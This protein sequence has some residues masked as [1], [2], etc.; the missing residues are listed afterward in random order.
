MSKILVTGA[1]G[2][3]GSNLKYNLNQSGREW[4]GINSKDYDLTNYTQAEAAIRKIKPTVI[5]HLAALSGGIGANRERPYEFFYINSLLVANVFRAAAEN[6]VTRMIYTMGGC[7]YPNMSKSPISEDDM[8]NGFPHGD[9]SAYSSAK[10]LGI[11]A[12]QAYKML[13]LN[14]TVLVP[15]NLYGPHDNY[16]IRNSHVIPALIHKFATAIEGETPFV[17]LWGDGTP[18]RDFVYVKDVT[19]VINEMVDEAEIEGPLNISSGTRISIKELAELTQ[20]LMG[21]NGVIKWD[22]SKPNGQQEKIFDVS[23]LNNL[24]YRCDTKIEKGLKDTIE[25]FYDARNRGELRI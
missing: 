7:S 8:W 21:Y 20:K 6:K 19:E 23:K 18:V 1:S 25:W 2:F 16:S 22:V 14:S 10:K 9:S 4:I 17:E 12:A 15:G 11:V 24:G 13:G 3:V 5:I